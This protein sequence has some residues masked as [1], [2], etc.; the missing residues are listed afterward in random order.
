MAGSMVRGREQRTDNEVG[1]IR[2]LMTPSGESQRMM[3]VY[4]ALWG[5]QSWLQPAFSRPSVGHEGSPMPRK[6]RLKGGCGQDCPPHMRSHFDFEGQQGGAESLPLG[7]GA[8]RH[9]AA[10]AE[11]AMEQEV[12][13]AEVGQ[14]EALHGASHEIAEVALDAL[15]GDFAGQH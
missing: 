14:L 6:S 13:G 12:Q 2:R 7:V 1:G 3:K 11:R 10:A 5:S 15:G 9:G 4:A 8:Q